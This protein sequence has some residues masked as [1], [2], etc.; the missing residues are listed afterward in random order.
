MPFINNNNN[1]TTF[2]KKKKRTKKSFPGDQE[3]K[4]RKQRKKICLPYIKP[5]GKIKRKKKKTAWG[6]EKITK[7]L[8]EGG[9]RSDPFSTVTK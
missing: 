4:L 7:G 6:L 9:G 2:T 1:K 3:E 8:G 5:G